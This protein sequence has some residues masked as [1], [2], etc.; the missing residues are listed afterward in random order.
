MSTLRR[1]DGP[2]CS[3]CADIPVDN[4]DVVT[5]LS[6]VVSVAT[7]PLT[8]LTGLTIRTSEDTHSWW[9]LSSLGHDWVDLL[10]TF[11][12]ISR[13]HCDGLHLMS[14]GVDPHTEYLKY[15]YDCGYYHTKT[16]EYTWFILVYF[17][18]QV[19][20]PSAQRDVVH[21]DES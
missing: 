4:R 10:V 13:E 15:K 21:Q 6:D 3:C 16:L 19:D 2:Q 14:T 1:T 17:T 12:D 9:C 18:K 8:A 5:W 20:V 7:S 11:Q